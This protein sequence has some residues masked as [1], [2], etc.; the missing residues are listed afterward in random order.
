[1]AVSELAA[2]DAAIDKLGKID[3]GEKD[4]PPLT[5][6]ETMLVAEIDILYRTREGMAIAPGEDTYDDVD[7]LNALDADGD[8]A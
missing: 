2:L 4:A 6:E 7:A 5:D 8:E 3:A 1:M